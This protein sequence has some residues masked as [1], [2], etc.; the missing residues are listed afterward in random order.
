MDEISTASD[1]FERLR[2]RQEQDRRQIERLTQ[3]HLNALTKSLE[4]QYSDALRSTLND[5]K[6]QIE[7]QTSPLAE[8]L[9]AIRTEAQRLQKLTLR[10]WLR[11][12]LVGLSLLL[13]ASSVGASALMLYLS[14]TIKTQ[15]ET[16]ANLA[17]QIER[18]S[19][20]LAALQSKA[21]G[22]ELTQTPQGRFVV[23]PPKAQYSTGWTIDHR[24]AIRL[25]ER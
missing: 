16:R 23:L 1:L 20:T 8:S 15:I 25:G 5:I 10:A 21:W 6:T 3:Q 9:T 2:Q 11:P 24:Q 17:Q 19:K 4:T 7:A 22:V 14:N 18:Q 12:L 13:L